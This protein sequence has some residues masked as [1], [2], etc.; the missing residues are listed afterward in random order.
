MGMLLIKKLGVLCLCI[1]S[2]TLFAQQN[3]FIA[4][5]GSDVTGDGSIGNPFARSHVFFGTSPKPGPGDT[6]F[7]RGGTYINTDFDEDTYLKDKNASATVRIKNVIGTP[8]DMVVFRPNQ[9]E[10][11]IIKS[12]GVAGIFMN[13]SFYVKIEGFEVFGGSPKYRK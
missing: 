8:S 11:V 1:I 10:H 7:Y 13:N 4:T 6:V 9:N 2:T 3:W 5:N 12:N